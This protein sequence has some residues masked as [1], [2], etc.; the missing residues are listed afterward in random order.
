MKSKILI[1][2]HEG[3]NRNR[4]LPVLEAFKKQYDVDMLY[5]DDG[6]P[7]E[8]ADIANHEQYRAIIWFVGFKHLTRKKPFLWGNFKG[9]RVMY[10]WDVYMNYSTFA[11]DK[12]FGCW[13]ETFKRQEFDTLVTTGKYVRDRLESDGVNA[14]W[15]P[16]GFDGNRFKNECKNRD[17]ICFYGRPYKDRANMLDVVELD[18][19]NVN[20]IRCNYFYLSVEL[21]K[22]FGCVMDNGIEPMAKHF[23]VSASGCAPITNDI[24]ELYSLGFEDGKTMIVYDSHDELLDELNHYYNHKDQLQAIG[25]FASKLAKKEHTWEK[26]VD[27]FK[28]VL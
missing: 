7:E 25:L 3:Y 27:M 14:V 21:N 16:K 26:R 23:E 2:G 22:Y 15:I 18:G 1:I 5:V 20:K 6:W 10:D 11:G 28:S 19:W 4:V 8:I 13:P 12:Y 9:K 24:D 17:G